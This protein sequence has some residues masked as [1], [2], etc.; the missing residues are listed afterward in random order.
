[1]LVCGLLPKGSSVVSWRRYST[2]I[3]LSENW[4]NCSDPNFYDPKYF[5]FTLFYTCQ[6]MFRTFSFSFCAE[7]KCRK[8]MKY[9][10][11]VVYKLCCNHFSRFIRGNISGV[12]ARAIYHRHVFASEG[13]QHEWMNSKT[14]FYHSSQNNRPK[15][16]ENARGL[17]ESKDNHAQHTPSGSRFQALG[18]IV[19]DWEPV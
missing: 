10:N 9:N 19:A 15:M 2:N 13:S 8:Y 3:H 14:Q 18:V 5:N 1:M 16:R 6:K 12:L 4:L 11:P 17:A 7:A